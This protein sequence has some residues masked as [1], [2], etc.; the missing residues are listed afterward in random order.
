M[1]IM[2]SSYQA[3]HAS[4]VS[5]SRCQLRCFN[6]D[7]TTRVAATIRGAALLESFHGVNAVRSKFF[8]RGS[9]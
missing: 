8:L 9:S 7:L 5:F 6:N 2:T 1:E 4:P 3:G